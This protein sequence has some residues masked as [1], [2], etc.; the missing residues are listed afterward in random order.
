M[1]EL[2]CA[3]GVELAQHELVQ[4]R[5]LEQRLFVAKSFPEEDEGHDGLAARVLNRLH[6]S[7][8]EKEADTEGNIPPVGIIYMEQG[9][10]SC[11]LPAGR[12]LGPIF[13]DFDKMQQ[14]IRESINPKKES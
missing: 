11:N 10:I 2:F 7:V 8:N 9:N 12:E 6:V 14:Y 1:P 4:H 13:R 5:G 3:A